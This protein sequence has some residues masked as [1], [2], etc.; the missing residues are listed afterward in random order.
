MKWRDCCAAGLLSDWEQ[1]RGGRHE[2]NR[3]VTGFTFH[4]QKINRIQSDLVN[5]AGKL[6]N[7]WNVQELISQLPLPH[8]EHTEDQLKPLGVRIPK[9]LPG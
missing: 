7:Y 4:K 6:C 8:R 1:R 9:G 5:E 3:F 2:A